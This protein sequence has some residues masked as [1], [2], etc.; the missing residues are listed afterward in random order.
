MRPHTQGSS[1]TGRVP[2]PTDPEL[3]TDSTVGS[4]D[5]ELPP[6]NTARAREAAAQ[7]ATGRAN[8]VET[9]GERFRRSAH[10]GRLHAYA[11]AAVAL[12]VV[13]IA[14]AATNTARVRV[15][16]L[17]GS[18]RISLVW[19]VLAAAVIGWILGVLTNVRFQWLTRAPRPRR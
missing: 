2:A 8:R 1:I 19:L 6:P 10:Q 13:L 18:S 4:T 14:L 17:V 12:V 16:W 15:D 5:D 7:A 3:L 9:R 11:I